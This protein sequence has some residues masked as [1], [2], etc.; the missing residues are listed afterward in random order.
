MLKYTSRNGT[1]GVVPSRQYPTQLILLF[2]VKKKIKQ[3]RILKSK[4]SKFMQMKFKEG[5]CVIPRK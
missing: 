4:I 1:K 5:P 3:N 2:V